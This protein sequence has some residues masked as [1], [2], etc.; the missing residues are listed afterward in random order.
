MPQIRNLTS[1]KTLATR[2]QIA[3]GGVWFCSMTINQAVVAVGVWYPFPPLRLRNCFDFFSRSCLL[4]VVI[5]FEMITIYLL[6]GGDHQVPMGIRGWSLL[7]KAIDLLL[8]L[9]NI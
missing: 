5:D 2:T 4:L 7:T 8:A 9:Y 1:R 3:G 6:L